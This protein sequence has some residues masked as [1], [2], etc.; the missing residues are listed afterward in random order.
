MKYFILVILALLC[1]TSAVQANDNIIII[2]DTSGSMGENIRDVGKSRMEVAQDAMI[3]VLS[4]VPDTTKVG[5]LS[6]DGWIY[7]LS[8]VDRSKLEQAIRGTRPGGG[9]PLY[10]FIRAGATELLN[11]REDQLNVGSYKLLIV[12]DGEAGDD[13]LNRTTNFKD[14]SIRLGVLDD[15]MS[16]NVTIDVIGLDMKGKHSLA[17]MINGSYMRGDD[18]S[19]LTEAVAQAVAEVS[20]EDGQ[21]GDQAFADIAEL[22]D[23]AV[24][25]I[26]QG[27]TTFPNHPIGEKPPIQV[28]LEDGTITYEPN[29]ANEPI[30]DIGK[31][32][33]FK[34]FMIIL[35]CVIVVAVVITLLSAACGG[36]Y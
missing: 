16:R 27:L 11:Q 19:S 24:L 8:Q 30:D 36:R 35:L 5:I 25:G 3:D 1:F 9:T 31:T 26:I 14:D 7:P 32:S 12:T 15:V 22:P 18:P 2:L 29:P 4:Q 28:I 6:F 34:V 10:E 21:A 23:G 17:T 33:G 20:F 13:Y